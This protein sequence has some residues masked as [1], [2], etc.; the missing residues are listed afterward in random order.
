MAAEAVAR[1]A[2]LS[3]AL[4][5]LAW[6][7][8]QEAL[9]AG[10]H[11]GLALVGRPPTRPPPPVPLVGARRRV[12]HRRPSCGA[13][14]N[15][16]TSGSGRWQARLACSSPGPSGSCVCVPEG[17]HT[18][19]NASSSADGST[20]GAS[21]VHHLVPMDEQRP[22]RF[23]PMPNQRWW[24]GTICNHDSGCPTKTR[25]GTAEADTRPSRRV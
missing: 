8:S 13:I 15:N 9:T 10:Q 25:F 20:C 18:R 12:R 7:G 17:P 24:L 3:G 6:Q 5:R 11:I 4:E 16:L 19:A 2:E 14:S 22:E 1:R 21:A 23:W